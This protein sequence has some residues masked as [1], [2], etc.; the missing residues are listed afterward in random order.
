MHESAA[1]TIRKADEK[2]LQAVE[3]KFMR[4]IA[5]ITLL[6]HKRDFKKT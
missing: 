2:M 6:D 3:I 4:K 1:W 5:G